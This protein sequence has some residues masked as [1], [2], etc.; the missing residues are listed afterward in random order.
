M[1]ENQNLDELLEKSSNHSRNQL[2]AF[3]VFS[4]YALVSVGGT[5]DRQL[6]LVDI[7]PYKLP[8]LGIELPL[9]AF[10]AVAP[11][12]LVIFHLYVLFNLAQH[13]KT[14]ELW[15]EENENK[16]VYPFFFNYLVDFD[17]KDIS[18]KLIRFAIWIMGYVLPIM[19]LI[20]TQWKFSAFH[21]TYLTGWHLLLV[22]TDGIFLIVY[23]PRITYSYLDEKVINKLVLD[24]KK[25]EKNSLKRSIEKYNSQFES[26]KGVLSYYWEEIKSTYSK[27]IYM[28]S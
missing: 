7:S 14:L 27:Q 10:F 16:E 22:L 8:F 15:S 26:I 19:V 2:I 17:R 3:M 20:I 18:H 24:D 12:I 23:W 6:L 25:L 9:I 28:M 1:A 13:R 11:V 5:S 4:I 21:E